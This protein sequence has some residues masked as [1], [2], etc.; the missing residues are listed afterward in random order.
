MTSLFRPADHPT[1]S[2]FSTQRIY[3]EYPSIRS[4]EPNYELSDAILA[5]T[6]ALVRY[7]GLCGFSEFDTIHQVLAR[8]RKA[9]MALLRRCVV[10][11]RQ[12]YAEFIHALL[13]SSNVVVER[14]I[15]RAVNECSKRV[16]LSLC[17][18]IMKEV[19]NL[20][21]LLYS[22]TNPLNLP[23]ILTEEY[24]LP[25]QHG[26]SVTSL[27]T[28][29]LLEATR[30]FQTKLL[31]YFETL[32]VDLSEDLSVNV[33][34]LKLYSSI[35]LHTLD[36]ASKLMNT[37]AVNS[38]PTN[39]IFLYFRDLLRNHDVQIT[40]IENFEVFISH[41]LK[42]NDLA[43]EY[44]ST[45]LFDLQK[46]LIKPTFLEIIGEFPLYQLTWC[47]P[48]QTVNYLQMFIDTYNYVYEEDLYI[49]QMWNSVLKTESTVIRKERNKVRI[50][51][52]HY[53]HQFDHFEPLPV[54]AFVKYF[55][56]SGNNAAEQPE[57]NLMFSPRQTSNFK[58]EPKIFQP[59]APPALAGTPDS[60]PIV[61]SGELE[62]VSKLTTPNNQLPYQQL[63]FVPLDKEYQRVYELNEQ[64]AV[65]V[66][67]SRAQ[68][69]KELGR[70]R[71]WFHDDTCFKCKYVPWH[72]H[73]LHQ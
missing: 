49:E 17:T 57:L 45:P 2:T 27:Q 18:L 35:V 63:S 38:I 62:E 59:C 19:Y 14:L 21:R 26:L 46:K 16:E 65:D 47:T 41:F 8:L 64:V 20:V 60:T 69:E 25:T 70:N 11:D 9:I 48:A 5:Q 50:D 31:E 6:L 67:E 44:Q 15:I 52:G 71:V 73:K 1:E 4:E 24:G 33:T 53:K 61:E 39:V 54:P 43:R 55:D 34:P 36:I 30:N 29:L 56:T 58:S 51:K 68:Y 10:A 7:I 13:R 22:L 28:N 72:K 66:R 37:I 32:D 42:V 12:E 40:D 23:K 3:T